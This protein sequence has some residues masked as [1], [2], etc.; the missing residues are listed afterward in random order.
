[1]SSIGKGLVILAGIGRDDTIADVE[2]MAKRVLKVKLWPDDDGR[3]W[4]RNVQ[5]IEGEIL[6]G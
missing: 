3:N 4:R 5:D 2:T 1:V 6:C